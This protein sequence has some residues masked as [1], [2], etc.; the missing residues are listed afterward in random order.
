MPFD[1]LTFYVA[2]AALASLSTVILKLAQVL[3]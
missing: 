3:P 1:E 2:C